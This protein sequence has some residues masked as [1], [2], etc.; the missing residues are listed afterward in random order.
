MEKSPSSQIIMVVDNSYDVREILRRQLEMLGYSVVEA[1]DGLEA[2]ILAQME[3]PDLI[4]MGISLP[5]L[6]GLSAIRAI[7]WTEETGEV[8]IV[9]L[10][11][12]RN[13]DNRKRA[14]E[15]GCNDFAV[16]PVSL[17]QLSTLMSYHLRAA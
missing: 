5:N 13:G 7:R 3:G 10:F 15:A 17:E 9:A 14:L 16:A 11:A 6:D 4:L 12:L 2:V 1:A 8:P